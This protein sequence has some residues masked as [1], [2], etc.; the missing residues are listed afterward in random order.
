VKPTSAAM[1]PALLVSVLKIPA[2]PNAEG[3]K[4]LTTTVHPTVSN[5][6]WASAWKR[7]CSNRTAC[8]RPKP[9]FHCSYFFLVNQPRTYIL[10]SVTTWK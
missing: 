7:V 5:S 9:S 10:H 1:G 6:V 4:G 2:I 8:N 3:V